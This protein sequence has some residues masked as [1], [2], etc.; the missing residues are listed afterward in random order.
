MGLQNK[1]DD[2]M[3]DI[4]KAKQLAEIEALRKVV[5]AVESMIGLH[6]SYCYIH[7]N[8]PWTYNQC[9]CDIEKV[10]EALAELNK[11]KQ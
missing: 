7:N 2:A 11:V 1:G 3:S 5:T 10:S 9:N 4:E 8:D 6:E